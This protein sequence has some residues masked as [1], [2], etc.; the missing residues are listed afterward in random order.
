VKY[1]DVVTIDQYQS[2]TAQRTIVGLTGGVG[3]H[4]QI[5]DKSDLF[6]LL[7]YSYGST[8][9]GGYGNIERN[10]TVALVAGLS[11]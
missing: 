4:T 1:N 10:N 8:M 3:V 5:F 9:L 11:F 2:K 7:S 6:V